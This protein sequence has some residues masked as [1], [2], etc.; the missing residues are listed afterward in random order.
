MPSDNFQ[1]FKL[2]ERDD[3]VSATTHAFAIGILNKFRLVQPTNV[4]AFHAGLQD[5]LLDL[6]VRESM[7]IDPRTIESVYAKFQASEGT[8]GIEFTYP[9]ALVAG[10]F[11]ETAIGPID[12]EVEESDEDEGGDHGH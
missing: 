7:L 12:F 1:N 3:V 9:E 11:N 6:T 2:N 8:G 4:P 5:V 10:A